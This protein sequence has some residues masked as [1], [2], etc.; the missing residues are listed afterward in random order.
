MKNSSKK[1]SLLGLSLLLSALLISSCGPTPVNTSDTS[2]ESQTSTTKE[3]STPSEWSS[4]S[5]TSVEPK[6][7]AETTEPSSES[8]PS[9]ET[10]SSYT[11]SSETSSE[12]SESSSVESYET[13]ETSE[14]YETEETSSSQTSSSTNPDI[15][16]W[17]LDF[18]KYGTAFLSDLSALVLGSGKV[19][20]YSAHT[21]IGPKAAAWPNDN[22]TTFIPF[23]HE[24]KQG[25]QTTYSSCNRE[26]TWPDSRGGGMFDDDPVMVRPTLKSDNSDR[27]NKFYGV[28][29]GEWDPSSCGYEGARGESARIILYCAVA[30]YS[31]GVRLTNNPADGTDKHT[32]GTLKTLLKWNREYQ[33]TDFERTVNRRLDN[34]GYRRNPFVDHPEYADYIWDDNGFRMS[35]GGDPGSSTS[36]QPI[37]GYQ[38][39]VN[40]SDIKDGT[41]VLI[42]AEAADASGCYA[43]MSVNP[44]NYNLGADNGTMYDG[45]FVPN[46]DVSWWTIKEENGGY[47]FSCDG[48]YVLP[49]NVTG[50]DGKAHWNLVTETTLSNDATWSL[51]GIAAD[52]KASF[53]SIGTN[54]YLEYHAGQ[55]KCWT[56]DYGICLY[57]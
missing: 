47:T 2:S 20:S 42:V 37:E 41:E 31:K 35:Q 11:E 30:Y 3:A 15:K 45:T 21:T 22:S 29:S 26:H 10:E 12:E 39:I 18:S 56:S 17:N 43:S 40:A 52:G 33:P 6:T 54:R 1:K 50:S 49:K 14:S 51:E 46:G 38:P 48:K 23:Y 25:Q 34:M 27:G 55:F 19:A 13:I 5:E 7:S 4:E 36:I 57:C 9:S 32:M 16:D 53:K 8:T 24:A 44:T 28:G